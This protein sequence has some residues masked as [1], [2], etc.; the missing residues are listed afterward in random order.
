MSAP[1][2][3]GSDVYLMTV[4]KSVDSGVSWEVIYTP[5]YDVTRPSAVPTGPWEE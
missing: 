1:E 3:G 2:H 4:W 5:F